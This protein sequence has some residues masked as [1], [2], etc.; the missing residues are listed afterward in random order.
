LL[1]QTM[2][3]TEVVLVVEDDEP[4]RATLGRL[5]ARA[6]YQVETATDGAAGLARLE[7][8]GVDVVLLDLV[9]PELS[10]LEVCRQVRSR[11][12]P[13]DI[14]LPIIMLTGMGSETDRH[15]G[16]D[17]GAD[18]YIPKPFAV[19]DLLDRVGVWMRARQRLR[20][21]HEQLTRERE[22]NWTLAE[23]AARDEAI[24]IMA[25]TIADRLAQ[26]LTVLQGRLALAKYAGHSPESLSELRVHLEQAVTDLTERFNELRHAVRYVTRDVGTLKAIDLVKADE[27][28]GSESHS[29]HPSLND[30][31]EWSGTQSCM[32]ERVR[33]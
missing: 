7:Q 2:P 9:M 10:G 22:R 30:D 14:Y 20:A 23:Q 24:V 8:G 29:G 17:A 32:T 6:G 31:L 13:D 26:P 1:E 5:L 27:R 15:A 33:A 18:D 12:R 11:Q 28:H 21:T 4:L 19:A 16:F 3:S 25:C